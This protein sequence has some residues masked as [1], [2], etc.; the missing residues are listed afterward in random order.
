MEIDWSFLGLFTGLS[1]AG[2]FIG[3][4]L[5]QFIDGKKLKKGFGCFVFLMGVYIVYKEFTH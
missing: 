3:I 1:V 5:N 4:W 2:I